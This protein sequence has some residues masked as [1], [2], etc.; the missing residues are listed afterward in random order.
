MVLIY[1]PFLEYAKV[2]AML[3]KKIINNDELKDTWDIEVND[4]NEYMLSNGCISHNTSGKAINATESILPVVNYL[5]KEDGTTNITTLAP[6]FKQNNRYYKKAFDCDQFKLVELSAIRQMYL[7]QAQ[8]ID[9]YFS[10]PDSYDD[11]MRVHLHAFNLGV[12]TL[13]YLK[14]NKAGS[15]EVCESCT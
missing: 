7:D 2:K 15:D 3:I 5:Y 10:R 11:L 1:Q 9:L 14:Q 8:S 4:G 13:Y 6:N 12:K